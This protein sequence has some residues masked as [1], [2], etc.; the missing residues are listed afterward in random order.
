M[1]QPHKWRR[2]VK[3]VVTD[4][5]AAYKASIGACLPHARHVLDRFHVI[6]W[7]TAALTAV[8]RDTQRRHDGTKPVGPAVRL[9]G[10]AVDVVPLQGDHPVAVARSIDVLGDLPETGGCRGEKVWHNSGHVN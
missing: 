3:V 9:P 7:F 5:S 4:G 8:R 1:S 2:G 6:R 10:N